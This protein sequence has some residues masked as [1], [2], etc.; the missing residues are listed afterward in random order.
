M[1]RVVTTA[2][3]LVV[4]AL[5]L[6][7]AGESSFDLPPPPP[8]PTEVPTST[9]PEPLAMAPSTTSLYRL[10]FHAGRF[11]IEVPFE[12]PQPGD[13]DVKGDSRKSTFRGAWRG[14]VVSLSVTEGLTAGPENEVDDGMIAFVTKGQVKAADIELGRQDV[15][16]PG[17][18]TRGKL[19]HL[20]RD[21]KKQHVAVFKMDPLT[22][23]FLA[24]LDREEVATSTVVNML[25]SIK[26]EN[27][28]TPAPGG[29][30]PVSQEEI[31]DFLKGMAVRGKM[32]KL[33]KNNQPRSNTS[34]RPSVGNS[35]YL[36]NKECYD[37]ARSAMGKGYYS[38]KE[39]CN[40]GDFTLTVCPAE[41]R[42]G[43]CDLNKTQLISFYGA[44]DEPT[45]R[46]K[47]KCESTYKGKW[48]G[49]PA[50]R[51]WPTND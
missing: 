35:C 37:T 32:S 6:A 41:N 18:K 29:V 33:E 31:T 9:K 21:G 45:E 14:G 27:A 5:G 19:V 49:L 7:C 3:A 2:T 34:G 39:K 25:Q 16:L 23:G 15:D 24:V 51:P 17:L 36:S 4:L 22:I 28:A 42:I 26:M 40:L 1:P 47:T 8:V 10:P 43:F 11:S 50:K 13:L 30:K 46:L 20:Q 44:A 38:S 48:L 12:R